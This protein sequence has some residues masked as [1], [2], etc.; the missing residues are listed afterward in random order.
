MSLKLKNHWDEI[1]LKPN[2]HKRSIGDKTEMS[3]KKCH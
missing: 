1:S 3:K 2:C